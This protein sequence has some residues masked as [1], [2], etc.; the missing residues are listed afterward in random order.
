[1][2]SVQTRFGNAKVVRIAQDRRHRELGLDVSEPAVER[3]EAG[4]SATKHQSENDIALPCVGA[5]REWN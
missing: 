3:T 2:R 1:M 5:V 4:A